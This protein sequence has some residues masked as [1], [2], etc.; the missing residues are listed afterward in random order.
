[1]QPGYVQ[2]IQ[3]TEVIQENVPIVHPLVIQLSQMPVFQIMMAKNPDVAK[4]LLSEI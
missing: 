2:P 4:R 1:M 3:Q